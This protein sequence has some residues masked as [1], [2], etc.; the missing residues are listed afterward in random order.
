MKDV[1]FKVSSKR[2]LFSTAMLSA[3]WAGY[4]SVAF[5]T[6][7]DEAVTAVQSGTISGVVVDVNGDP[8]IGASVG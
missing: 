3:F 7:R 8:I 6:D 5:A 4:P 2:I 1:L